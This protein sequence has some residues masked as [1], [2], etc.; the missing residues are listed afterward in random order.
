MTKTMT[1]TLCELQEYKEDRFIV[2]V[3]EQIIT[4]LVAQK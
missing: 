4:A 1:D 3:L 2:E